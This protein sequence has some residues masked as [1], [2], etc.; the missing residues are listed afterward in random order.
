MAPT[1]L[2][3]RHAGPARGWLRPRREK[4]AKMRELRNQGVVFMEYHQPPF[5][6]HDGMADIE[7]NYPSKGVRELGCWF[8]DSEGNM[9]GMGQSL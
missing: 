8:L 1:T 9:L 3:V 7:G 2:A 6:T 5:V 4:R